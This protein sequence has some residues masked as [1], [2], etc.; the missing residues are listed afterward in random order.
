MSNYYPSEG[1]DHFVVSL[2]CVRAYSNRSRR[3]PTPKQ[4][5]LI[6]KQTLH[7]VCQ[8]QA[9]GTQYETDPSP[10]SYSKILDPNDILSLQ[11]QLALEWPNL[12]PGASDQAF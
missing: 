12:K 3:A 2:Q 8:Q 4:N 10:I 6:A 1:L 7:G 9:D 11:Q 5:F